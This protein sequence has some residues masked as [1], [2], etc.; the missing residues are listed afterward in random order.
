M[1]H[2]QSVITSETRRECQYG[3]ENN[4]E[5]PGYSQSRTQIYKSLMA[6]W[7]MTGSRAATLTKHIFV[8]FPNLYIKTLTVNGMIL[9]G[10]AF[11][12]YI[13]FRWGHEVNSPD[14][15]NVLIRRE[16]NWS[17]L[18]RPCTDTR[19]RF[20]ENQKGVSTKQRICQG[21]DV[22]ILSFLKYEKYPWQYSR[23]LVSLLLANSIS[24]LPQP[25]ILSIH[26]F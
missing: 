14:G 1:V 25:R 13:R 12:R 17:S 5:H 18:S 8:C 2:S 9:G 21:L 15:T 11:G 23:L 19:N 16:R 3:S 26:S 10:G 20:S 22:G 4:L 7:S 6:K 24:K